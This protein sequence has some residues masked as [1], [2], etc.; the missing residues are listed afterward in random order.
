MLAKSV[1]VSVGTILL[2]GSIWFV[3]LAGAQDKGKADIRLSIDPP[4]IA[5]D[6]R[7]KYD[8]DIVYVRGLRRT[9]EKEARWAEFSRPHMMEPGADLML[10][11][12][13]G[14]EEV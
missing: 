8:Y 14:S 6:K 10:L 13:D 5:S 7:V 9:D 2:V 4:H 12:P 3:D 1:L 11:R